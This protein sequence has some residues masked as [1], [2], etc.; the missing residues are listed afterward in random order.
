MSKAVKSFFSKVADTWSMATKFKNV[1]PGHRI[2]PPR[3]AKNDASFQ[4]RI[5]AGELVGDEQ[6]VD[7]QVNTEATS[8]ALRDWRRKNGSHAK[9]ATSSFNTT[10]ADPDAEAER[11]LKDLEEQAK[12][13]L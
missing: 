13:N 1:T 2:V 5:D 6:H 12:K 3:Q 4:F 11:V 9:L 10:A 7:L 8:P